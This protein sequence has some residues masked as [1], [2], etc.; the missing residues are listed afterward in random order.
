MS[1]YATFKTRPEQVLNA[2]RALAPVIYIRTKDELTML[3]IL[4][5]ALKKHEPYFFDPATGPLSVGDYFRRYQ[6]NDLKNGFYGPA[7]HSPDEVFEAMGQHTRQ[8]RIGFGIFPDADTLLTSSDFCRKLRHFVHHRTFDPRTVGCIV[9]IGSD[10]D[11][12]PKSLKGYIEVAYDQGP[13]DE[14]KKDYA[15]KI[16]KMLPDYGMSEEIEEAVTHADSLHQIDRA[17]SHCII[18]TR[19]DGGTPKFDATIIRR[20]LDRD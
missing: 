12:I 7:T 19:K 6:F 11:A 17:I 5:D 2:L 14:D 1:S 4:A 15:Q 10:T 3:Q 16:A 20:Y 9:L 18:T 8:G 13:N